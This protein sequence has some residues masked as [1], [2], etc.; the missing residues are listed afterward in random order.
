MK[1]DIEEKR[2]PQKK[3]PPQRVVVAEDDEEDLDTLPSPFD[4][5]ELLRVNINVVATSEDLLPAYA[6]LGE[7]GADIKAAIDKEIVIPAGASCLIPTGLRFDIPNGFEIQ[8][9]PRSGL[10][11]KHQITVLNTPGT[12]DS[13]F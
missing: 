3:K 6:T 12:V 13:D 1:K 9:R 11:L 2:E 7:A 4:L 5:D 8:V 10:A